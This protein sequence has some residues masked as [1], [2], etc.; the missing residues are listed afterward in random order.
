VRRALERPSALRVRAAKVPAEKLREATA[1]GTLF[2]I[3][4]E[5]VDAVDARPPPRLQN[6]DGEDLIL[7]VD[8]FDVA[9]GKA[10]PPRLPT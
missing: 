1:D 2:R 3:W 5:I 9:A 10:A 4:Q 7:T 8:R 6:T